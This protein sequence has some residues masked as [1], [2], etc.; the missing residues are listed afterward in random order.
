MKKINKQELILNSIIK[1]YLQENLPIGSALLQ[2]KLL[3]EK[4]QQNIPASTIRVYFKRLTDNGSLTKLHAS[5]GRIPTQQAMQVFWKNHID[6][7]DICHI[8]NEDN[9]KKNV[10]EYDIFCQISMKKSLQ[11]SEVLKVDERFLILVFEKEELILKYNKQIEI[12]IKNFIG[13]DI[14][15]I[16]QIAQKV[17][18]EELE[19]KTNDLIKSFVL[20]EKGEKVFYKI[21]NKNIKYK[22]LDFSFSNSLG[23][24][25]IFGGLPSGYMAIKQQSMFQGIKSNIFCFGA[26]YTDFISFYNNIKE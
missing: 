17:G 23:L 14:D 5:G 4:M 15:E 3:Q 18:L 9:L 21:P 12:F 11:L 25:I 8:K 6:I 1:A 20:F 22:M 26:L 2:E 19:Q 13:Y 24:G 16:N 10:E 7:N